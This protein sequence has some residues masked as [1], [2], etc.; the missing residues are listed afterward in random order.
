ML[1]LMSL[2]VVECALA[3]AR[4]FDGAVFPL[5]LGPKEPCTLEDLC[6][7]DASSQTLNLKPGHFI[8]AIG[9]FQFRRR[10]EL[11]ALSPVTSKKIANTRQRSS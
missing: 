9:C 3:E 7:C 11:I 2:V 8:I 1:A 6:K 5:T 10:F 4:D